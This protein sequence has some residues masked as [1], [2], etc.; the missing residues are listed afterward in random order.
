MTLEHVL[1]RLMQTVKML[2]NNATLLNLLDC[3]GLDLQQFFAHLAASEDEELASFPKDNL[4]V[5]Q[6]DDLVYD[7]DLLA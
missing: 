7:A 3:L 2:P 4:I 1:A 6:R 5:L